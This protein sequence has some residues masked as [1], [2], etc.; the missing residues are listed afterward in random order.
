MFV[1]YHAQSISVKA[2]WTHN[3]YFYCCDFILCFKLLRENIWDTGCDQEK[4]ESWPNLRQGPP[5]QKFSRTGQL[6]YLNPQ[7]PCQLALKDWAVGNRQLR[8]VC[9]CVERKYMLINR[10]IVRSH[11]KLSNHHFFQQASYVSMC[12]ARYQISF[13][14]NLMFATRKIIIV[15]LCVSIRVL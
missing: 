5:S 1:M 2:W 11:L 9:V 4:E 15:S 10:Y 14:K 6:G 8:R 13:I 3:L 7:G 12:C